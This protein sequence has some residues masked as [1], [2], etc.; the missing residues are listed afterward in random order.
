MNIEVR[1]AS[2]ATPELVAGLNRLLP[3]LSSSADPLDEATVSAIISSPTT[4]LLVAYEGEDVV[5]SL[6]LCVFTIPT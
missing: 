2:V 1:V 4:S 6:T 3:Q 5:G